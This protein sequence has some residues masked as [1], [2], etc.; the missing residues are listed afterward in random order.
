MRCL[1][2]HAEKNPGDVA[3]YP[4]DGEFDAITQEA[5]VPVLLAVECQRM[6][7]LPDGRWNFRMAITCHDCWHRL[8]QNTQGIDM[9][10][11]EECWLTL[12]PKTPFDDL[13]EVL[14][15]AGKWEAA[16]YANSGDTVRELP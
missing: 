7:H 16:S 4:Y 10:I 6:T 9:W 3:I 11:G 14:E 13:P 1:A 2:C 8:G 12:G 5:P 15:G